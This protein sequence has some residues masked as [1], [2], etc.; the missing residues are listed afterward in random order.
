MAIS[1]A[2]RPVP[3]AIT[4]VTVSQELAEA[5]EGQGDD[6]IEVRVEDLEQIRG[7]SEDYGLTPDSVDLLDTLIDDAR[8]YERSSG[9]EGGYFSIDV[10]Y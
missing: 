7:E 8:K 2:L 10:W 5:L 4:I 9:S 6:S 1:I 3:G